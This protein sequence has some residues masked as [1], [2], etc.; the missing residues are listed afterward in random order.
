MSDRKSVVED[1]IDG[2]RRTDHAGILACLTDD[3]VWAIHGYR[4][5]RGK[6]A[7]DDEIESDAA[8]GS[9]ALA[10]DRLIEEDDTVV[11][12][13]H[14]ETT[15]KDTGRVAFVFTELFTFTGNLIHRIETFHIN[16][17]DTGETLFDVLT[18]GVRPD[19]PHLSSLARLDL[20]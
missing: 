17:G 16:V 4:T 15:L 2:F 6:D 18:E 5:L 7:F 9:P 12:V 11:P 1:Y 13:G 8:V 14:G 19:Q 3:V 20:N 10:L